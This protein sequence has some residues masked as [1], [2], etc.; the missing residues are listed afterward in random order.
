MKKYIPILAIVFI[1]SY[2]VVRAC[3]IAM[4]YGAWK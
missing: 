1:F 4:V 3:Y 2:F